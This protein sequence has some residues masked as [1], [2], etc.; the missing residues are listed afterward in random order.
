MAQRELSRAG[1]V[2]A[3]L[4]E[5]PGATRPQ[6][7]QAAGLSPAAMQGVVDRLR[8]GGAIQAQGF[9]PSSGGRRAPR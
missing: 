9:S 4:L 6:L 3:V 7:C 5:S 1:R 8:Q 2:L